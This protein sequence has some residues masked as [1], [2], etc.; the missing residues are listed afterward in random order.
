MP[1]LPAVAI[2]AVKDS[3]CG[4]GVVQRH[5]DGT[6]TSG[7]DVYNRTTSRRAVVDID[8]SVSAWMRGSGHC[9][10]SN[11]RYGRT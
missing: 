4:G 8:S 10:C 6:F 7:T 5:A 1:G 2:R 3:A 9:R 11:W